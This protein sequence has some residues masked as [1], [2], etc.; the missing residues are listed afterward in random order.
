MT[1]D[2]LSETAP[3]IPRIKR[4]GRKRQDDKIQFKGKTG[5]KKLL[6]FLLAHFVFL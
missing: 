5:P 6:L 3:A 1:L 4:C 2:C